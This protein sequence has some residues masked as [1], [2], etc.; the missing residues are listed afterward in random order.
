MY[1][2]LPIAEIE[3]NILII[4]FSGFFVG[5][6]SGLFG[7]GG[8]FLMTPILIFLG[9]PPATA[10]AT[11]STQIL[12]SSVSGA[13]AHGRKNNID[14][15]IGIF[16]LVGGIFGSTLGVV[17]FKFMRESG[18]IDLIISVMYIIFLAIIGIL[19]FIESA[20]SLFKDSEIKKKTKKRNLLDAL[21][22]KLKFRKSKIYKSILLP[23]LIG[24]FVGILSALMGVGGGFVMVPAMIYLLKMSTVTAIGTSLFQIVFVTANVTI[25][26]A[27]YNQSVDLI[28]AIFLLIGGVIGAQIGSRYTSRF[29]GEQ[30]RILLAS[31][32]IIVCFKMSFDLAREPLM[33]SRIIIQDIS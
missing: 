13:T 3:I 5:F 11:E 22:L 18:N 7:V 30:L 32:V 24:S 6:L 21:P 15:E 27:T 14:Y 4:L 29:K 12:G 19:M 23:I 28:L 16:L 9:I 8:G 33:N 26:Q 31:V 2:F 1:Y 25:L 17:F 10:V 20:L